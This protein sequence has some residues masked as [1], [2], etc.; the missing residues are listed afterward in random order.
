MNQKNL[1]TK[2]QFHMIKAEH[3]KVTKFVKVDSH[4]DHL[5]S[6]SRKQIVTNK[7]QNEIQKEKLK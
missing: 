3:E 1:D 4:Y 7:T 5:S 2:R 6:D